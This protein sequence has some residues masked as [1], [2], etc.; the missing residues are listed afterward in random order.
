LDRVEAVV[1][2]AVKERGF[3]VHQP[4]HETAEWSDAGI[5]DSVLEILRFAGFVGED[6]V[7]LGMLPGAWVDLVGAGGEVKTLGR[8]VGR[9][10]EAGGR[11]EKKWKSEHSKRS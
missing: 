9:E 3:V 8:R 6:E 1:A 7:D 4:N 11:E 10:G 2:E 5:D